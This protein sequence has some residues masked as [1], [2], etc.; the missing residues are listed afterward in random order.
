MISE[1]EKANRKRISSLHVWVAVLRYICVFKVLHHACASPCLCVCLCLCV[2]QYIYPALIWK[3]FRPKMKCAF[4][5][6]NKLQHPSNN[7]NVL[8]ISSWS[9]PSEN[10]QKMY[11][12]TEWSIKC[13]KCCLRNKCVH[14]VRKWFFGHCTMACYKYPRTTHTDTQSSFLLSPPVTIAVAVIHFT[15]SYTLLL[16]HFQSQSLSPSMK[17]MVESP[18]FLLCFFVWMI[19]WSL[20]PLDSLSLSF[21][22]PHEGE[23]GIHHEMRCCNILKKYIIIII[24]I[25]H[26]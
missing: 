21:S 11:F 20:R 10:T 8:S 9:D 4:G 1:M 12:Q 6:I 18:S 24:Y 5:A 2:V 15:Y 14:I 25:R 23:K 3:M 13:R 19:A 17:W 16:I 7:F 22:I 26:Y